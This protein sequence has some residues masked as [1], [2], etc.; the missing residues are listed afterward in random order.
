MWTQEQ[1][2]EDVVRPT[3]RAPPILYLT[4]RAQVTILTIFLI[5]PLDMCFLGLI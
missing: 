1:L 4:L 3:Q 2:S 5:L